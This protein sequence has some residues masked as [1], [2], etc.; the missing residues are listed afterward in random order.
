[1]RDLPSDI[2]DDAPGDYSIG[3]VADWRRLE[4]ILAHL[5]W[6]RWE[7]AWHISMSIQLAAV[8]GVLVWL[9]LRL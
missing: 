8:T 7:W 5:G 4:Q 9:A 1:M 3:T 6:H 2:D